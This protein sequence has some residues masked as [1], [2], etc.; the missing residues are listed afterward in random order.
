MEDENPLAMEC[1]VCGYD[2]DDWVL[3]TL[4][5][6]DRHPLQ[7]PVAVCHDCERRENDYR[8]EKGE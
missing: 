1:A 8:R 4:H 7:G 2:S 3:M 5:W 6:I